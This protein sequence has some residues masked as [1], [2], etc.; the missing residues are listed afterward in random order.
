MFHTT[1]HLG[2]CVVK[3]LYQCW[4]NSRKS[5]MLS[6]TLWSWRATLFVILSITSSKKDYQACGRPHYH[7]VVW[8]EV[9][10]T[11]GKDLQQE[12][13]SWIKEKITCRILEVSTNPQLHRLVTKYQRHKCS[14]Y[15]R[16]RKKNGSAF[17]T[18]CRFGF[19]RQVSENGEL[20]G[21]NEALKSNK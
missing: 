3:T 17:V 10:P 1:I 16:R 12:V 8:I 18:R 14:S 21:V 5:F 9:A 20:N 2:S 7:A 11:I 13:M 6:S 19:P 15:C 4:E